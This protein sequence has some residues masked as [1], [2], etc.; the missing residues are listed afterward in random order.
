[1]TLAGGA[2]F[3][4]IFIYIDPVDKYKPDSCPLT[5]VSHTVFVHG[6]KGK[7]DMILQGKGFVV[8]DIRSERKTSSI[9]EKGEAFFQN[10]HAGDNI[11]LNI[12]FSEPYKAINPDSVYT[13]DPGQDIYLA[14]NLQGTDKIAGMVLFDESPLSGV[15][16]K[17][18]AFST[19][20]DSTGGFFLKI[21]EAARRDS[22]EFQFIKSGFLMKSVPAFPQTNQPL[23]ITMEKLG[24]KE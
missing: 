13:I 21:P 6:P 15:Q 8:L 4:V 3:V 20:T 16:V 24:Q 17:V 22:Y 9:N 12:D 2:A 14:I 5:E 18:D 11:R 7:Q 10:L 1:M 19:T 23:E